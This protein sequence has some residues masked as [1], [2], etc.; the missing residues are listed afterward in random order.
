MQTATLDERWLTERDHARLSALVQRNTN[1]G[2]SPAPG[3]NTI[4]AL[5][6]NAVLVPARQIPANVVTM[7]SQV[8]VADPATQQARKFTLCYPADAEPA[9][10]FVSV[11]SPVGTALLGLRPGIRARW[12]LPGGA[13]VAADLLEV[14]FQPEA[15]GDYTL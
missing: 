6:D 11:L 13:E 10:G 4:E 1:S 8:L 15:S 5:L 9:A 7:Y 3:G 12:R 2:P 14:L